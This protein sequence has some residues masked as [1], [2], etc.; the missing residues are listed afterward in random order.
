MSGS[1]LERKLTMI[2]AADVTGYSRLMNEDEEATLG[3]LTD[4]RQTMGAFIERHHGRIVGAAGDSVLA[5]FAS[6]VEA[7]R[8][9]VEVQQELKAKNEALPANRRMEFRIGINLGDVIVK[10]GDLFGDGVNIAAR[11]QD[12]AAPGGICISGPVF[13]QVR[14]KL[15]IGFDYLGNRSVK[16]I[17]AEVAVYR[18]SLGLGAA[19]AAPL[20]EPG[21]RARSPR[22]SR[23][24][25][26]ARRRSL[27]RRPVPRPTMPSPDAPCSARDPDHRLSVCHQHGDERQPLVVALAHAWTVARP[28]VEGRLDLSPAWAARDVAQ[29]SPRGS[30]RQETR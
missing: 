13:E 7:V 19:A 10:D 11:L 23:P 16:H 8:C 3:T 28:R 9:A 17:A 27:S 12:L 5:E 14:N 22:V 18:V 26:P 1:G 20:P 29:C 30:P 15:T 25:R 4:Y 6:V 21:D 24:R 2:F